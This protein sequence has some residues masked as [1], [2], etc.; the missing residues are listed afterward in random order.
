MKRID[1]ILS[2]YALILDSTSSFYKSKKEILKSLSA[3]DIYKSQRTLERYF[4]EL[5]NKGFEF[6]QKKEGNTKLYKWKKNTG[7]TNF[8]RVI[9]QS[10]ISVHLASTDGQGMIFDFSSKSKLYNLSLLKELYNVIKNQNAISFIYQKYNT[11]TP[12]NVEASPYLLKQYNNLWYLILK[13]KNESK[14][15]SYGVDRMLSIK[16]LKSDFYDKSL[17]EIAKNQCKQQI[18]VSDLS[19]SPIIIKLNCSIEQWPYLIASPI[20]NSQKKLLETI[21]N[22]VF[23]IEVLPNY[24]LKQTLFWYL[25]KV[26][27]ME[28]TWLIKQLKEIEFPFSTSSD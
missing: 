24:E 11:D 8:I 10:Y 2:A 15:K 20:H 19:I 22:V 6:E 25:G 18:G 1:E 26:K 14:L 7:D 9:Q 23:T 28:P 21:S 17:A 27:V 4:E 16:V 3:S 5:G 12:I 13:K